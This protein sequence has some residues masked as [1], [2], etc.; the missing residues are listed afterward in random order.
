[1]GKFGKVK[2]VAKYSCT[3][4]FIL[5]LH[6]HPPTPTYQECILLSVPSI[7]Q[8]WVSKDQGR[9]K[10]KIQ[11]TSAGINWAEDLGVTLDYCESYQ[12]CLPLNY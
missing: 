3:A 2:H 7:V 5:Y 11:T 6:T 4:I 9:H 8:T 12:F 10:F 1:M